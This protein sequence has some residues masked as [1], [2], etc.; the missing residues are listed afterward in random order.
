[1]TPIRG[2]H[3]ICGNIYKCEQAAHFLD[4]QQLPAFQDWCGCCQ[5]S[6]TFSEFAKTTRIIRCPMCTFLSGMRVST[7]STLE[8]VLADC[9]DDNEGRHCG[10]CGLE[11]ASLRGQD[12]DW[13]RT[14]GSLIR[15]FLGGPPQD[16]LARYLH[17]LCIN[18]SCGKVRE[19]IAQVLEFMAE[20]KR[21]Y[22]ER[23][24]KEASRHLD[25]K[26]LGSPVGSLPRAVAPTL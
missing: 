1:M 16:V 12:G 24:I 17:D 26:L 8:K 13:I 2:V 6:R 14:A 10:L 11:Y 3:R 23:R 22:I 21:I 9:G 15:C 20:E 5:E 7:E 25:F 19:L 18:L 4:A